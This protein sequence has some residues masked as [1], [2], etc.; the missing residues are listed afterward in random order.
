M[1]FDDAPVKGRVAEGTV[2]EVT[3]YGDMTY[4]GIKLDGVDQPLTISMRNLFG[5]KVL[6]RG[7]RTRVAWDPGA[8]VLFC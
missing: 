7:E 6:E 1:L 4:Y 2:D 3:Y 8:L 5:R